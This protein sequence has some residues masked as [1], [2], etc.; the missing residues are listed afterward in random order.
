ME[1]LNK[2]R[3]SR[4]LPYK[5]EIEIVSTKAGYCKGTIVNISQTGLCISTEAEQ[6]VGTPIL[7]RIIIDGD[8]CELDGNIAWVKQ[9]S[10]E[11]GYRIGVELNQIPDNYNEIYES[12]VKKF[13]L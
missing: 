7:A 3:S 5:N 4:R 9:S 2:K 13:G 6:Y 1:K 11:G 8:R 10:Q 12:V